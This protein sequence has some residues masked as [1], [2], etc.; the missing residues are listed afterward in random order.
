MSRYVSFML[1]L[2]LVVASL[3]CVIDVRSVQ[4]ISS[5]GTLPE[6]VDFKVSPVNIE[7]GSA[8][9]LSW[10]VKGAG[11]IQIDHGVGTVSNAGTFDV[12]PVYSTTYKITASNESGTRERYITLTVDLAGSSDETVGCDPVTGRNSQ[13]DLRWEDFCYSS[14]YQVQISKDPGFSLVVFDSGIMAPADSTSPAFW[15]PPGV[16]EAGHTYYWRVRTRQAIT[17]QFIVSPWSDIRPVTVRPGFP[18]RADYYGIQALTPVNGCYG[19]PVKPVSFSWSGYPG[20]TRYRFVLA[21]DSQL[22][23]VIVEGFTTT[24]SYA[25]NT[26]LEYSTSYFWQVQAFEP[27]P[28]DP[29]PTVTLFTEA[30]P[31]TVT[32]R[33]AAP[34]SEPPLW[35]W[36]VIAVCTALVA[37]VVYFL[38]KVRY[39]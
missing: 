35:A 29:C 3:I 20:T 4:A 24:T 13:I 8:A 14:Q 33:A 26:T 34:S 11:S 28:S 23:N 17:G 31:Q 19:C 36:I 32:P 15:Y 5:P 39:G 25:L 16:L 30:A 10:E 1:T 6:I 2:T 18:V 38:V 37:V 12:S 9:R 22:Q 27:I 7:A 21:R